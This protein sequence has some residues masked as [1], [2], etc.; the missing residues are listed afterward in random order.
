MLLDTRL[1]YKFIL[2]KVKIEFVVVALYAFGIAYAD[3][4]LHLEKMSI[5]LALPG[6]LGTAISLILGFRIAQSYDR[7]WEA[8]KIWGSI[9]NDSRTLVRQVLTLVGK[10]AH[11]SEVKSFQSKI[12]RTQ[13]AWCYALGESLRGQDP[14]VGKEQYL[15]P[16][17]LERIAGQVNKPNAILLLQA[18]Y[19]K[20]AAGK[21]WLNGFQSMLIDNT[22]TRL[23]DAMGMSERIK[24]TVFPRTYAI[25]V[26][27]LLYLFVFMLP[28]GIIDFF[29]LLEAPIVILISLPF[30]FLEKA[31]IHLQDPFSGLPTD[32]PVTTIA[33]SIEVDLIQMLGEQ[34]PKQEIDTHNSFYLM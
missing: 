34:A 25:V 27:F 9:V 14:M 15:G 7:W 20:Q 1:P 31:A 6:I 33:Q 13:I 21:N 19:L 2:G 26:E 5:P 11:E 17:V 16:E 22:I 12:A 32:T 18:E 4:F 23:T 24:K 8:R 10:D 3:E 28:F 30:F 29:G